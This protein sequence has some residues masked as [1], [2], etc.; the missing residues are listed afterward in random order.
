[1]SQHCNYTGLSITGV[2]RH[3]P[4][5]KIESIGK[6]IS[7]KCVTLCSINGFKP[8]KNLQSLH[9]TWLIRNFQQGV[10]ETKK[11]LDPFS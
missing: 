10:F 1:M 7:R 8:K 6:T 9:R 3:R 11:D 5:I 2:H 4:S